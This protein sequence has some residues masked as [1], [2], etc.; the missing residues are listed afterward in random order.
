[1]NF[2]VATDLETLEGLLAADFPRSPADLTPIVEPMLGLANYHKDVE[3]PAQLVRLWMMF[4]EAKPLWVARETVHSAVMGMKH[5]PTPVEL[6]AHV[7]KAWRALQAAQSR[8]ALATRHLEAK[9]KRE[10][11][12]VAQDKERRQRWDAQRT[13]RIQALSPDDRAEYERLDA[14]G[15][16][17]AA[18]KLLGRCSAS[19]R[20]NFVMQEM[21]KPPH[22]P[23]RSLKSILKGL[24]KAIPLHG[25]AQGEQ[26]HD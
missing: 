1:M 8:L 6:D 19:S 16:L 22:I 18:A 15:E 4:F 7:P 26:A 14:S 11:S 23:T 17:I 9:Q 5:R 12:Q 13:E 10:Q 20:Q 24:P 21:P 2:E 3:G 25:P